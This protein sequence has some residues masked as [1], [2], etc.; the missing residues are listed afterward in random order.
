[1][2]IL[3]LGLACDSKGGGPDALTAADFAPAPD[4]LLEYAPEGDPGAGA[5]RITVTA[6]TWEVEAPDGAITSL[7]W[8]IA[9]TGL[10]LDGTLILPDPPTEG[11]AGDGVEITE[12]G[13]REVWYGSFEDTVTVSVDGGV[14]AGTD[15]F[16]KGLGPIYLTMG[17]APWELVYYQRS[18]E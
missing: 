18:V 4:L 13:S 6:T 12:S 1:M 7:P 3:V 2:W 15:V 9:G 11:T 5:T 10:T 16:G 8:E 17:G 14:L